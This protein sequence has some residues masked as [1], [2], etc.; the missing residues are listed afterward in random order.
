MKGYFADDT[1]DDESEHLK[2]PAM[3]LFEGNHNS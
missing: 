2:I 3:A 1:K